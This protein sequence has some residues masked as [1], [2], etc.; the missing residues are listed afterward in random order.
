MSAAS[1]LPSCLLFDQRCHLGQRV[2]AEPGQLRGLLRVASLDL[3]HQAASAVEVFLHRL[4][5]ALKDG[6]VRVRL[7]RPCLLKL[8]GVCLCGLKL[9][10]QRLDA[11]RQFV[12]AAVLFFRSAIAFAASA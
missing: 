3:L 1:F 10:L 11:V 6:N 9:G 8:L 12:C 2:P 5:E 4:K 7:D